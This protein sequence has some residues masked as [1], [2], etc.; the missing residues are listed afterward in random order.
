MAG[1]LKRTG[2]RSSPEDAAFYKRF[3][4]HVLFSLRK[5]A[6]RDAMLHE[7]AD[8]GV[9]DKT[10]ERIVAAVEQ[11]LALAAAAQGARLRIGWKSIAFI[12]LFWA[13]LVAY[14]VW[15]MTRDG[16]FHWGYLGAGGFI[17][18]LLTA[19]VI[20]KLGFRVRDPIDLPP[21]K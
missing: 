20:L 13:G 10:A 9:P 14:L 15:Q 5:G 4:D 16:T 6:G 7:L 8:K 11:E 3:H 18:L 12:V 17:A 1:P 21:P 19:R 2:L